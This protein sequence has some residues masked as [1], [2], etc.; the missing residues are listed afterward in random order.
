MFNFK[1]SPRNKVFFNILERATAQAVE[2]ARLFCDLVNDYSEMEEKVRRLADAEKKADEINHELIQQLSKTFVTPIDREDLHTLAYAI[3][4]VVD[5]IEAAGTMMM[6]CKVKQPTS[7]SKK[8]ANLLLEACSQLNTLMPYLRDMQDGRQQ[9][10]LIHELENEG[11]RLW[12]AAFA[13]LF[14]EGNDPLEV[15]KWKEIYENIEKAL[16]ATEQVAE[17]VEEVIEKNG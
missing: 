6:L 5:N 4:D 12:Q 3:D 14:E 13:S 17:I 10:I 2:A 11:D 1:L 16:D 9:Y 7:Y 8:M 15:I